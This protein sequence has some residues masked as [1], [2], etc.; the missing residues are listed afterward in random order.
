MTP[1]AS[2]LQ[3]DCEHSRLTPDS[4]IG[5]TKQLL[6]LPPGPWPGT[7]WAAY[8]CVIQSFCEL[9][10]EASKSIPA[11]PE[12]SVPRGIVVCGGGWRFFPSIY[13]ACRLI[14]HVGCGLPIQIWYLGD[15]GELDRR[16]VECLEDCSVDWIDGNAVWR[17]RPGVAIR[18]NNF[19]G[20]GS[21][22]GWSMKAFAAAY[23][24][25]R[26]VIFFDADCYPVY[27]PEKFMDHP[28]FRRV[29]A[30]FW[31][32]LLPICAK[33]WETF[34]LA[35]QNCP[36]LDSGQ[37]IVNKERHWSPL[38]LACWLNAHHDYVYR[39]IYGDKETFNL[40][41]RKLGQEM[42]LPEEL[43]ILSVHSMIHRDFDGRVL[44]VHRT[45]DKFKLLCEIDGLAVSS[46]FAT[47]QHGGTDKNIH[48]PA[49]PHED[50]AHCF[51]ARCNELLRSELPGSD[52]DRES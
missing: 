23:S 45:R 38:W 32:G 39:H 43:P 31:P 18:L 2:Q 49:L 34:G 11:P 20:P 42:C 30:A 6:R 24:P 40:A 51:A 7:G 47:R 16:M 25:Y 41:W 29:G 22:A 13:V 15:R 14:R 10:D 3:V 52:R 37:F 36:G 48:N 33:E 17:N 9:F 44:F 28:E 4:P 1:S 5:W 27:N 46:N 35:H 21:D 8:P 19:D 26:E 12:F 50:A